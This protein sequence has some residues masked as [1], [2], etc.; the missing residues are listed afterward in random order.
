VTPRKPGVTFHAAA[1]F[2][3]WAYPFAKFL[4][5][6]GHP[7]LRTPVLAFLALFAALAWVT[8]RFAVHPAARG[9]AYGATLLVLITATGSRMP[10]RHLLLAVVLSLAVAAV[11]AL[12]PRLLRPVVTLFLA[13]CL[14]SEAALA[15]QAWGGRS[16]ALASPLPP[17]AGAGG[18]PPAHVVHLI[19]DEHIGL[20]G[21]P[22]GAAGAGA[23]KARLRSFYTE[24]GFDLWTHAYS[25]YASS[26]DAIPGIL[27][28]RL[29][30]RAGGFFEGMKGRRLAENRLFDVYRERGLALAV[31]RSRYIDFCAWPSTGACFRY[32]DNAPGSLEGQPLGAW[33]KAWVIGSQYVSTNALWR[34]WG[35]HVPGGEEAL[36]VKVGPLATIPSA[37]DRLRRDI[38]SARQS[39]A[40]FA[41]LHMPHSPYVYD[42]QCRVLPVSEWLE[43][44]RGG[45]EERWERYGGQV[46][47][48][49]SWL[50][51]LFAS[52]REAG[53]LDRAT[54][55]LHG[56]HG[57]RITRR[58]AQDKD[59]ADLLSLHST[60]VAIRR[61]G[62]A[63]GRVFDDVRSVTDIVWR[64]VAGLPPQMEESPGPTIYMRRARRERALE[65]V[66]LPP[67][68]QG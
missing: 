20:A 9:L 46:E 21:L 29:V 61:A 63:E 44:D 37:I 41:H 42:A 17:P 18:G 11:F 26:Q 5:H 4:L 32:D 50:D 12:R 36:R 52:L 62:A 53:L 13:G 22:P 1:L 6:G 65:P 34:A 55:V 58:P 57:A 45:Y 39:T 14:V 31:Y 68:P 59:P 8:A 28:G 40:F 47:C 15:V 30:A 56:D 27:N 49:M 16:A 33:E 43:H 25:H 3:L 64:E 10:S 7:F 67:F 2:L 54:I 66:P 19:L 23:L 48:L 51:G 24:R 35:R 38:V 60:F